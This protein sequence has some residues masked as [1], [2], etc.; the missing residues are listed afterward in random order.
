MR[1]ELQQAQGRRLRDGLERVRPARRAPIH[2]SATVLANLTS[3]PRSRMSTLVSKGYCIQKGSRMA[4]F[5]L[6]EEGLCVALSP[7]H[8]SLARARC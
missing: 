7:S 2:L 3:T 8:F 4:K 5:H 1:R 6:S